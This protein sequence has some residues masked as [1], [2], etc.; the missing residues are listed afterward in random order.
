VVARALSAASL[1]VAGTTAQQNIGNVI[2]LATHQK[3]FNDTF[4]STIPQQDSTGNEKLPGL[5]FPRFTENYGGIQ[6]KNLATIKALLAKELVVD[7]NAPSQLYKSLK[8]TETKID[9]FDLD[10]YIP[11]LFE[12]DKEKI[13]PRYKVEL[14]V[15]AADTNVELTDKTGKI[16]PTKTTKNLDPIRLQIISEADLLVEI[17][18]DEEMQ[19]VRMGDILKKASDAERK[20]IAESSRM[21]G[22]SRDNGNLTATDVNQIKNSQVLVTDLIQDVAKARDLLTTLRSEYEKL[23]RELEY[24]RVNKEAKKK[25]ADPEERNP[26]YLDLLK[27]IFEKSLPAAET[28]LNNFASPLGSTQRPADQTIIDAKGKYSIFMKDLDELARKIG[29]GDDITKQRAI[30]KKIIDDEQGSGVAIKSALDI[31]RLAARMPSFNVPKAV[32]VQAGKTAKIKVA[33]RLNQFE[34]TEAYVALDIPATSEIKGPKDFVI[35]VGAS[36]LDET[37]YEF[38]ITGGSK[39]GLYS[40]RLLPGPFLPN[41]PIKPVELTVEVTK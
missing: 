37:V 31:I 29:E 4:A 28:A 12:K 13:Q 1:N 10:A 7:P 16:L 25:Y 5:P 27:Q 6:R 2:T 39:P 18:K 30:L 34:G 33:M 19:R 15:V 41:V 21:N 20:L 23:F 38:E 22:V 8:L 14:F 11:T 9:G 26:G 40:L 3:M 32:Q 17:G 24:N 36:D 35:K